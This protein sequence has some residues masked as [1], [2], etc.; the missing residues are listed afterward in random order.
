ML[1]CKFLFIVKF[2]L[3]HKTLTN[4]GTNLH[5]YGIYHAIYDTSTTIK[6]QP[7]NISKQIKISTKVFNQRKSEKT[8]NA[9]RFKSGIDEQFRPFYVYLIFLLNHC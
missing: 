9:I 3:V 5:F 8:R 1:T 2:Q 7:K 6:L 4:Y